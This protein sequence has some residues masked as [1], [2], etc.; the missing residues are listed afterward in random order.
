MHYLLEKGRVTDQ[1]PDERTF[2]IFYQLFAGANNAMLSSLMLD[3]NALYKYLGTTSPKVKERMNDSEDFF[4]LVKALSDV[5]VGLKTQNDIFRLLASILHLGN[6][7]FEYVQSS[8]DT[9][10][11]CT[12]KPSPYIE[13]VS[14]VLGVSESRLGPALTNRTVQTSGRASFYSVPLS[15]EQVFYHFIENIYLFVL[16]G[17]IPA[18]DW[19]RRSFGKGAL[20]QTIRVDSFYM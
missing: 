19:K 4:D 9:N 15:I 8:N 18:V 13:F 11:N 14:K 12:L 1:H 17:R 10:M 16:R 6:F 5:G 7:Q 3:G 2:H 20:Q